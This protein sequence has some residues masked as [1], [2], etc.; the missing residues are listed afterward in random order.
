VTLED[1]SPKSKPWEQR[2]FPYIPFRAGYRNEVG[3]QLVPCIVTCYLLDSNLSGKVTFL[4]SSGDIP[5]LRFSFVSLQHSLCPCPLPAFLPQTDTALSPNST[6]YIR[7]HSWCC[8][9]NGFYNWG[10]TCPHHDS[11]LK[12]DVSTRKTLC[13]LATHAFPSPHSW[14]LMVFYCLHTFSLFIERVALSGIFKLFVSL[15]SCHVCS[16]RQRKINSSLHS[17]PDMGIFVYW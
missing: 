8:V 12:S 13:T 4:W 15:G 5:Q 1:S 3:V 14:Q 10:M 16:L 17:S 11:I 2:G 6:L 7:P 9:F